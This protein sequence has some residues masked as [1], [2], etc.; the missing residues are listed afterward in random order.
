MGPQQ[1]EQLQ[2]KQKTGVH[3]GNARTIRPSYDGV[4]FDTGL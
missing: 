2:P 3:D 4:M 1:Q